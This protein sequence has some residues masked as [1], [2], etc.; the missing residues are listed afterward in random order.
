MIDAKN[1]WQVQTG[2][3]V[4]RTD[5]GEILVVLSSHSE[6]DGSVKLRCL[7]QNEPRYVTIQGTKLSLTA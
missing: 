4:R 7:K 6:P 5:G 1:L 2:S 3:R